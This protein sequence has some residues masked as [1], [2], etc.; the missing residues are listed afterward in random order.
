MNCVNRIALLLTLTLAPMVCAFAQTQADYASVVARDASNPELIYWTESVLDW[1]LSAALTGSDLFI[2]READ[3]GGGLTMAGNVTIPAVLNP[4][5]PADIVIEANQTAVDLSKF[6]L[7][8]PLPTTMLR[9]VASPSSGAY[10]RTVIVELSSRS[11]A[12]I[13]Y[14]KNG[15]ALQKYDPAAD[16]IYFFRSGTLEAYSEY[17]G[18][19]GPT[20]SWTYSVNQPYDSDTDYDGVPDFVE[21]AV[22]LDPLNFVA[23]S[24]DDGW[25][26][27]H[28]LVRETDPLDDSERPDDSDA[29]SDAELEVGIFGDGWSDYD[30]RLRGTDSTDADDFPSV[31]GVDTPEAV[32][33]FSVNEPFLESVTGEANSTIRIVNLAGTEIASTTL[34]TESVRFSVERSGI[35]GMVDSNQPEVV[36]F[37]YVSKKEINVNID[38]DETMTASEWTSAYRDNLAANIFEMRDESVIDA[39]S[40]ASVLALCYFIETEL[41]LAAPNIVWSASGAPSLADLD[42]LEQTVDLDAAYETISAA[43]NDTGLVDL[44]QSYI[45]LAELND[46]RGNMVEQI[47]WILHGWVPPD[48]GSIVATSSSTRLQS[49][50]AQQAGP[51]A[52]VRQ[53]MTDL[54]ETIE[55]KQI[56]ANGTITLY[57]S[58]GQ[59]LPN[60]ESDQFVAAVVA[61]SQNGASVEAELNLQGA[62]APASGAQVYFEGAYS[63]GP[64]AGIR[65]LRIDVELLN[66]ISSSRS[67]NTVD[68]DGNRL[69]DQWERFY[70]GET[71]VDPSGDDDS[72]GYTNEQEMNGFSDPTDS[73]SVPSG[74]VSVFDWAMY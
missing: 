62:P 43:I 21:E 52:S 51:F 71:G 73:G 69:V 74:D 33:P 4:I 27:I 68:S 32:L 16:T 23:D 65:P 3:A 13:F 18:I 50:S 60:G 38:G 40:T 6:F 70:F 11:G 14:R 56:K 28:E 57:D 39:E 1:T 63:D 49:E 17:S 55:R 46:I 10:E 42:I 37:T 5:W 72:D 20:I 25:L 7:S 67:T 15:G 34:G 64:G 48:A 61:F 19:P 35:L 2:Q 45:D 36:L 29:P 22:G 26:D 30:E 58:L 12:T 44:V 24:D 8:Q 66:V 47:A 9:T 31:I 59:A 53:A 41:S 54:F